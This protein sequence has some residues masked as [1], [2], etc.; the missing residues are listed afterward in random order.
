MTKQ[1]PFSELPKPQLKD[2]WYLLN[3]EILV[4]QRK[5]TQSLEINKKLLNWTKKIENQDEAIQSECHLEVVIKKM[6]Y[7]LD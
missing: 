4:G 3:W 7:R 1:R 6:Q 5:W 2:S